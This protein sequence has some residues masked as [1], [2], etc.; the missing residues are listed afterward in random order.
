MF[1]ILIVEDENRIANFIKMVL[2]SNNYEVLIAVNGQ[3]AKNM[4]SS[5][6]PDL[7]VLDLGLP[8][9]NG[10]E[11]IRFIREWS[12]MPIIVVSAHMHESEKV[13][14]LDAGADDYV[15]KPFGTSELL[16][17]IRTG[18]RHARMG[19][20]AGNSGNHDCFNAKGLMIDYDKHQVFVDGIQVKLT[21]NEFKL[22]SLLSMHSGKVLTYDYILNA[23]WGPGNNGNNQILRVHMANLRHKIEKKPAEPEYI[24]T[25]VGVGYRLIEM[26]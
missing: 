16:A 22:L 12:D 23:L 2:I 24:F 15:T 1:N 4:V 3:D 8:D 17:R 5:H 9:M 10:I 26:D 6:C 21:N 25:E 14:A 20:R 18:L 7:V 13:E 11:I 19:N